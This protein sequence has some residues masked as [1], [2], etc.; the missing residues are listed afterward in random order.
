[1]TTTLEQPVLF[2]IPRQAR[3]PTAVRRP[4][5]RAWRADV[6]GLR[7]VAVLLVVLYHCHVPGVTGGYV[8]VDVFFVISGFLITGNLLRDAQR[9]G[10]VH[11][12]SFYAARARRLVPLSVLVVTLTVVLGRL[13]TSI[14]EIKA[15]AGDALFTAFYGLNWRLAA[16]GINYQE[17]GGRI[18]PLQHFW[19]LAV[20]EQFYV[21][22]PAL[23]ALCFA[24]G[25]RHRMK[26][27]TLALMA[28]TVGSLWEAIVVT[29]RNAPLGYYSL[30]TRLWELGFGGLLAIGVPAFSR[31]PA[32]LAAVAS[33]VG[34]GAVVTSAFWYDDQTLFPGVS[35]LLPVL[36]ATTVL[37]AGCVRSPRSWSIERL[38]KVKAAQGIGRVSYGWY[39][40]HWP[41]L[42]LLPL[43]FGF[44]FSWVL[45]LEVAA[46]ALWFAV[47]SY[48]V[49]ESQTQ[50]TK[51]VKPKRWLGIGAGLSTVSVLAVV[52]VIVTVPALVGSGAAAA[53]IVLQPAYATS[54]KRVLVTAESVHAIPSNL[55]PTLAEAGRDLPASS[56]DNCH[57]DFLESREP[58]TCVYGDTFAS[59]TLVVFGDSHAQQWLPG[60]D[61]AGKKNHWKVYAWTKAACPIADVVITNDTLHRRFSECEAWRNSM[62]AKIV[63][64]HPDQ[65]V[66]AQSDG[67]PTDQV[68]NTTWTDKT[69]TTARTLMAA[70]LPVTYFLDTPRPRE[71]V[72]KCLAQHLD[73]VGACSLKISESYL[74][75]GRRSQLAAGL[76]RAGVT[77]LDPQA[78]LCA[79]GLCP[80]VVGKMLVYRDASHLSA[81]YSRWLEPLLG[82]LIPAG[83]GK[84]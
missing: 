20:E 67:V 29:A 69:A 19:S 25:G 8:G 53:P 18:S 78:W 56:G 10:R 23:I 38:L 44:E 79:D 32:G 37:A 74:Y 51:L 12:L 5:V 42:I 26:L 21:L 62:M 1:M 81:T 55:T 33:W 75:N 83:S 70:G 2:A 49:I 22:W 61:A 41:M 64:L 35:A 73:A 4:A 82:E 48:Y 68:T 43:A 39:L 31:V 14:F 15:L 6:Q 11:F 52:G 76:A 24:I 66:L 60:F 30:H 36:G 45:N 65:V 34:A 28:L 57:L 84:G 17:G 7:A 50:R 54:L 13:W 71:D 59:T 58:D 9:A 80:T 72:P 47:L 40:W 77:T 63:A 46:V 27:L 16:Q 3:Q